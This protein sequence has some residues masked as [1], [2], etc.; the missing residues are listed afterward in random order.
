[1]SIDVGDPAAPTIADAVCTKRPKRLPLYIA[2]GL[3]LPL[4]LL[5]LCA[6][7]CWSLRARRRA[8]DHLDDAY[9]QVETFDE[10]GDD[11][12]AS[13]VELADVAKRPAPHPEPP[14]LAQDA[15]LV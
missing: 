12:V 11:D 2:G 5:H 7:A 13:I 14:D 15:D 3:A 8:A 10:L 9:M 4:A 6:C 1:M